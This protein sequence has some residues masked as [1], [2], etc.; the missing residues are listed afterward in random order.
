MDGHPAQ[1]SLAGTGLAFDQ[2]SFD[3]RGACLLRG[4]ARTG[5]DSGAG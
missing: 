5:P 1:A 2:H 4:V 3:R